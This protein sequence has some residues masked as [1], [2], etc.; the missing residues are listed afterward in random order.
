MIRRKIW[1]TATF[2]LAVAGVARAQTGPTPKATLAPPTKDTAYVAR[3]VA[4]NPGYPKF[5]PRN[6]V[7]PSPPGYSAPPANL[8]A[9][10]SGVVS[11]PAE[12][13]ASENE[14]SLQSPTVTPA[15]PMAPAAPMPMPSV[16]V[17]VSSDGAKSMPMATEVLVAP[18]AVPQ[19]SVISSPVIMGEMGGPFVGPPLGGG[20]IMDPQYIGCDGCMDSPLPKVWASAEY[21]EWKFKGV[22]VPPLV[23]TAPLGAPGTLDDVAT[24]VL[25]GGPD[26]LRDW[27]SGYRLRAGTWFPDGHT[28]LDLGFFYVGVAS[29]RFFFQSNGAQGLFRPFYN[30]AIPIEDAQLVAFTDP[31]VGP[32]VAGRVGTLADSEL[33]GVE[34]TCR[35]GWGM[36]LGGRLDA[37]VGYRYLQLHDRLIIQSQFTTL[38]QLGTAPIGTLVTSSDRF[39]TRSQF[40]GGQVGLVGEWVIGK[41]TF[42]FRGTTAIGV[43]TQHVEITGVTSSLIPGGNA[44]TSA[45]GL[46]ALPTNMGERERQ[47]ISIVPEVGVTLG[48]QVTNNVRVFG[49]FNWLYWTNTL[50]AGEQLNRNVNATYIADPTTGV[51]APFGA[52]APTFHF[53]DEHFY[54]YGCSVG[55]EFR[56]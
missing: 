15:A 20:P 39:E 44:V 34:A 18:G 32:I 25:Y 56:Y 33:W 47:R 17:G 12:L 16:P 8:G 50:R 54:A 26:L 24:T 41:M 21:L 37:L 10:S 9:V 28:G 51:A 31:I 3:G 48:Y 49:G 7:A 29:E 1:A 55:L 5:I 11:G 22:T 13:F 46:L 14:V 52:P 53:R 4:P 36:G 35:M 6:Y 42:G 38:A 43:T 30:T 27:Q 23:T 19:G 45:G 40:N 2:C